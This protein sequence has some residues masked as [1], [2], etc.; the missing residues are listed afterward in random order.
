MIHLRVRRMTYGKNTLRRG[1]RR[2]SQRPRL[3]T[4]TVH[5]SKHNKKASRTSHQAQKALHT[6]RRASKPHSSLLT[7][8]KRF[9]SLARELQGRYRKMA[10]NKY[11]KVPNCLYF[12]LKKNLPRSSCSQ[13]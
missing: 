3:K 11:A 7:T 13:N 6:Q 9:W 5:Q 4:Q 8:L 10:Q 12:Y 1:S 2:S